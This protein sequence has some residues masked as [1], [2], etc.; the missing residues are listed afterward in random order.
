MKYNAS[1]QEFGLLNYTKGFV[2]PFPISSCSCHS[3]AEYLISLSLNFITNSQASMAVAEPKMP[4][5]D[6]PFKMIE[7]PAFTKDA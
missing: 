5:A 6:Q 4:W 2:Q 1:V 3:F 7:T